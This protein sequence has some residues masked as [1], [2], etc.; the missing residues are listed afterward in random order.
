MKVAFL[1]NHP[2]LSRIHISSTFRKSLSYFVQSITKKVSHLT[3]PHYH[4]TVPYWPIKHSLGVSE[5]FRSECVSV[6]FLSVSA[7]IFGKWSKVPLIY[8]LNVDIL[9]H[10]SSCHI[11]TD[12]KHHPHNYYSSQKDSIYLSMGSTNRK[13][14]FFQQFSRATSQV[15]SG[16]RGT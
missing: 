9:R 14:Y 1:T 6:L 10:D 7:Y 2:F 11:L 12:S 8:R 13:N 15:P 3:V 5:P 16:E 4:L